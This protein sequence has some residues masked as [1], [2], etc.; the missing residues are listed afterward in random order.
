MTLVP[1]I[2]PMDN[3]I[4]VCFEHRAEPRSSRLYRDAA[5][6]SWE[7]TVRSRAQ[8]GAVCCAQQLERG[9]GF[10]LAQS[11]D[12][13]ATVMAQDTLEDGYD[14]G[15]TAAAVQQQRTEEATVI[16]LLR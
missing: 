13:S 3:C 10:V 7:G 1:T 4:S 5:A 15:G 16:T 2:D 6:T 14:G 12:W 8:L 11:G 9:P